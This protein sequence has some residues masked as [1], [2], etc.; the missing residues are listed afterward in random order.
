MPEKT[1]IVSHRGLSGDE[2]EST[3]E[4]F[5]ATVARGVEAIE[6][7][8]RSTADGALVVFHDARVGGA[9]IAESTHAE[10]AASIPGLCTLDEVLEVVPPECLLD[11]EVKVPGFEEEL[12]SA[13]RAK[14]QS[15]AFIVTSFHDEVVSRVKNLDP[16]VRAGLVL[17]NGRPKRGLCGRLSELFPA[18]RLSRSQ[19]DLVVVEKVLLWSGVAKRITRL[20]YPVWVWT[21]NKPRRM[22]RMLAS[23]E[24]AAFVTDRP[25]E[26]MGLGHNGR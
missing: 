18:S 16:E 22:K 12:L 20:G 24:V 23:P 6:F 15:D 14:R 11:V 17:G 25:M 5:A 4:A 13:L 26:A 10:L 2:P 9:A 8:V 1:M 21:V 3:V 19:S 7:D